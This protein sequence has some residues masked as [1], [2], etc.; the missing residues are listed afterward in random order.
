MHA[1]D[2]HHEG[3]YTMTEIPNADDEIKRG[4]PYTAPRGHAVGGVESGA[5]VV[6]SPAAVSISPHGV[7]PKRTATEAPPI[8]P[9]MTPGN[10]GHAV[11]KA[12]APAQPLDNV[13]GSL[14]TKAVDVPPLHMGA[15]GR[16]LTSD[17]TY[18]GPRY[19]TDHGDAILNEADG[20]THLPGAVHHSHTSNMRKR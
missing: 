20:S 6:H 14:P 19:D 13:Q 16:D 15:R 3:D 8:H 11:S 9:S 18:R 4:L 2:G 17:P 1:D 10:R 5:T 7:V 12:H